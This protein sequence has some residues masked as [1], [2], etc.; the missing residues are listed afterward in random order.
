MFVR[1]ITWHNFLGKHQNYIDPQISKVCR[2]CEE[3]EETFYHFITDCP[4]L[5]LI[6]EAV[7]LDKLFPKDNSWS[8]HRLKLFMLDPVIHT[9]LT[10][11]AGLSTIEI[12][13]H[14]IKLPSDMDSS[15]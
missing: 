13:P 7:F 15:L 2:F 3:N 8:I 9:T 4:A 1:T 6:R 12:E 10:S 5:R 11:K 14:K